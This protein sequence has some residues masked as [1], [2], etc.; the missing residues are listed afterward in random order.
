MSGPEFLEVNGRWKWT[1]ILLDTNTS[2]AKAGHSPISFSSRAG[3]E[4]DFRQIS[5]APSDLKG[6]AIRP[7]EQIEHLVRVAAEPCEDCADI[8]FAP[9]QWQEPDGTG[10]N[11]YIATASGSDVAGCI[12]CF[13]KELSALK[14]SYNIPDE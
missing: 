4:E 1:F 7:K 5:A 9:P 8:V 3:A 12:D 14:A 11:W 13:D 2:S 6:R 10:C